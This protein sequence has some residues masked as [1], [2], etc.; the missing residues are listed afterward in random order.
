MSSFQLPVVHRVLVIMG[1]LIPYALHFIVC[2][3]IVPNIT[4]EER[5]LDYVV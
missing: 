1:L 2:A 3:T 4:K 5:W